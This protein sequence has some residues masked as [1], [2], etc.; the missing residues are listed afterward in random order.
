MHEVIVKIAF[1]GAD[2]LFGGKSGETLSV[3]EYSQRLR[4]KNKCIDSQIKLQIIY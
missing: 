2:I 1:L 3:H 4:A